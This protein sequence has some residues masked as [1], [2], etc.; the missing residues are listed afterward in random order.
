MLF[1]GGASNDST[2]CFA[3]PK[4]EDD[5]CL[6]NTSTGRDCV[7][8][9]LLHLAAYA[10][11]VLGEQRPK[12]QSVLSI[13]KFRD[14]ER[15]VPGSRRGIE[16]Q[17]P[18]SRRFVLSVLSNDKFRDHGVAKELFS[19]VRSSGVAGP[20]AA[21]AFAAT[22]HRWTVS[23]EVENH[24]DR[25]KREETCYEYDDGPAPAG[26]TYYDVMGRQAGCC[27]GW[28]IPYKSV[29]VTMPGAPRK[30]AL[31]SARTPFAAP[32]APRV[33]AEDV[34][35]AVGTGDCV[36]DD[37]A[38]AAAG[39]DGEQEK[40]KCAKVPA[41]SGGFVFSRKTVWQQLA[42]WVA[43]A[44]DAMEG[45]VLENKKAD[46]DQEQELLNHTAAA[47]HAAG[48]HEV[49]LTFREFYGDFVTRVSVSG[50]PLPYEDASHLL[51]ASET[52]AESLLIQID[53]VGF[54]SESAGKNEAKGTV[55]MLLFEQFGRLQQHGAAELQTL[56]RLPSK[57][58][59][60][61]TRAL[62]VEDPLTREDTRTVKNRYSTRLDV[63]V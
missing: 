58:S 17:V 60:T 42:V 55:I 16:R 38:A 18:G 19:D 54:D 52:V 31:P 10:R 50:K 28:I 44:I 27:A 23:V 34:G 40:L 35:G 62:G 21:P 7:D 41:R 46:G 14:L 37:H 1:C 24:L 12:K 57:S 26:A 15:Q 56:K 9:T 39:A 20:F 8:E 59:F 48:I 49:G 13:D 36:C 6:G 4:G 30:E 45:F 63:L 47:L 3:Y 33:L 51:S 11:Q 43:R 29:V 32:P 53:L 5:A 2:L 22:V 61:D 25:L